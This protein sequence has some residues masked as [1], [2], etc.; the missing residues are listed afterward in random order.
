MVAHLHGPLDE[1]LVTEADVVLRAHIVQRKI[2]LRDILEH[3]GLVIVLL[4]NF[5]Q[6]F[7]RVVG[8]EGR[9]PIVE[10][11][12]QQAVF[13]F[14]LAG[15]LHDG[16]GGLD[17]LRAGELLHQRVV[18]GQAQ[19]VPQ[20]GGRAEGRLGVQKQGGRFDLGPNLLDAPQQTV[21]EGGEDDLI[22]HVGV[23]NGFHHPLGEIGVPA[24]VGLELDVHHLH[25]SADVQ[26]FVEGGNFLALI[27]GALPLAEIQLPQLVQ[28]HIVDVALHA[29]VLVGEIIVG[30]DQLVVFGELHVALDAVGPQALGQLEGRQRVFGRQI[31]RAAVRNDDRTHRRYPSALLGFYIR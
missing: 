8:E 17:A 4:Q 12:H 9:E 14:Q 21:L 24:Q 27:L 22:F 23:A 6:I 3:I 1:S 28:R 5:Q 11:A 13:L 26:H 25:L 7:A 29:R 19:I 20:H 31:G 15:V 16:G 2:E 30:D 10:V 18:V